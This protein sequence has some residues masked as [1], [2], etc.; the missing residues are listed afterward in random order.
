MPLSIAERSEVQFDAAIHERVA[1]EQLRMVWSHSTAATLVATTFALLMASHFGRMSDPRLVTGWVV[2]K[3]AVAALRVVLAQTY[4]R[5]EYPGGIGWRQ[6]TYGTLALDGAVWGAAAFYLSRS[7]PTDASLAI[8]SFIGVA[9]GAT[10][11]LQASRIATTAYIVPIIVPMI[12]GMFLRQDDLGN[13]ASIGLCLLLFQMLVT[14]DRSDSRVSE[15]FLLNERTRLLAMHQDTLARSAFLAKVSHE[16]RSPLQGIV[17]ALDVLAM[18]HGPANA[19]DD[20]LIGRIRRSSLLLNTHLRDLLTLAKGEAGRLEMRSEPFDACLL[21]ESV[22]SSASELAMDKGLALVVDVPVSVELVV[23]DSARIDQVLTNLVV[24]S[25]RYTEAGQVRLALEPYDPATRLLKFSV[26]DTGPGIPQGMLPTLLTPDKAIAGAER[27]GEGSGIGLAIVRTLM[28]HLGGKIDVSSRLG[29]GTTF[30]LSIPAEAV[31][32][33]SPAE[34]PESS[35]GRILIVDDRDDVLDALTSVVEE[36]GF[37]YDRATSSAVGANLLA[38][39]IYDAALID[40]EMPIRGGAALAAE[41]RRRG[42]PNA[43]IR[44]IGMS[45]VEV[46][47]EQKSLFDVCLV[48]PIEHAALRHALL[49]PGHGG[50]PSQPGLW[51]DAA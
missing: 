20:E 21:V 51:P 3:I 18:R 24:N 14:A 43:T 9:C 42:G 46:T 1:D 26:S 38:S 11:G 25:I 29:K 41:T 17:S 10:F 35:T 7:Q 15:T 30:N 40:V 45:A 37:E 6:M 32:A 22:A 16:L 44:F 47:D 50:R 34:M 4:R 19:A 33:E 49:G 23:A 12:L 5:S 27:R 36:L 39:R 2:A 31:T 8:A 48:K 28:D 13:Y